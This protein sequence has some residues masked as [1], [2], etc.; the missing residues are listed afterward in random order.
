MLETSRLVLVPL[1]HE[2]LHL[3]KNKQQDLAKALG[4]IRV[5]PHDDPITLPH[6]VEAIEFWIESTR[7]HPQDFAWYTNWLIILK[8]DSIAIGGIGFSGLP[9]E[10]KVIVGYGLNSQYFGRNYATEALE[11]MVGWAFKNPEVRSITADTLSEHWGSQR[12][13]VKNGFKEVGRGDG[14]IYWELTTR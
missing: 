12:V 11:A 5:A 14:L 1:T 4:I 10:G 2:Q 7:A 9:K 8:E 6:L 3:Y 13:L